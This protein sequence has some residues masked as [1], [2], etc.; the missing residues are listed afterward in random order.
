MLVLNNF[1]LWFLNPILDFH[2][3][4]SQLGQPD[5]ILKPLLFNKLSLFVEEQTQLKIRL[6]KT[7]NF[8]LKSISV[9]SD[10]RCIKLATTKIL[11]TGFE[12]GTKEDAVLFDAIRKKARFSRNATMID[13]FGR[14]ALFDKRIIDLLIRRVLSVIEFDW[15]LGIDHVLSNE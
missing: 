13:M 7:Q 6:F 5:I 4:L 1:A 10:G 2:Q 15:V 3:L 11:N 14:C 8:L 12:E 9:L